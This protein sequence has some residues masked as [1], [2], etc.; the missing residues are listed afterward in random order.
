VLLPPSSLG[1][2]TVLIVPQLKSRG[3]GGEESRTFVSQYRHAVVQTGPGV[4]ACLRME[5]VLFSE[6]SPSLVNIGL[7]NVN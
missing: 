4:N 5:L 2:Y 6:P 1:H 3:A 7:W